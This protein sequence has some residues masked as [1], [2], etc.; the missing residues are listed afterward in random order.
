MPIENVKRF[1]CPKC[2]FMTEDKNRVKSIEENG[3]KCPA[4]QGSR[5]VGWASTYK[6]KKI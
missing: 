5:G 1:H 2:D 3:G 6:R 4:C